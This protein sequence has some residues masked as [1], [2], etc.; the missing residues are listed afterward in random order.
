[1][2][3]RAQSSLGNPLQW[4][5]DGNSKLNAGD[6][7]AA[8]ELY[9]KGIES[10][11]EL[12][13]QLYSNRAQARAQLGKDSDAVA[14]CRVAISYNPQNAKPYWQAAVSSLRLN[15]CEDAVDFCE[16]A[17]VVLP[18]H[19]ELSQLLK[20]VQGVMTFSLLKRVQGVEGVLVLLAGF[21]DCSSLN[22]LWRTAHGIKEAFNAHVDIM[23]SAMPGLSRMYLIGGKDDEHTDG[24]GTSSVNIFQSASKTW[25]KGKRLPARLFHHAACTIGHS[26]FVSG[27]WDM[28]TTL[29]LVY[30]LDLLKRVRRWETI[31]KMP[32]KRAGH[33]A[34]SIDSTV[35]I[36]GGNDGRG[37]GSDSPSAVDALDVQTGA[38]SR[39]APMATPRMH[40]SSCSLDRFGYVIGGN[41][42][43]MTGSA[44]SSVER[45]DLRSNTWQDVASLVTPRCEAAACVVQGK[46][47]ICGG[48]TAQHGELLYS[49]ESYDPAVDVWIEIASMSRPR[50]G[51]AACACDG[52]VYVFG[53]DERYC[54]SSWFNSRYERSIESFDLASGKWHLE[55]GMKIG[56]GLM[57][58]V[59]PGSHLAPRV[60]HFKDVI[61]AS[62][63]LADLIF[64][65]HLKRKKEEDDE[66]AEEMRIKVVCESFIC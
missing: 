46:L 15:Q 2:S 38:W 27:G 23:Q 13:S 52:T 60:G 25:S 32:I 59:T 47:F 5:D 8:E 37:F 31:A 34:F 54:N 14:D 65:A 33:V 30:H 35:F 20:R 56:R 41:T 66:L 48:R 36:A 62:Q 7:L 16:S 64:Q 1:M 21:S 49:S 58:G 53:S 29:D 26:I 44:L 42:Y 19:R 63:E 24:P 22:S 61:T 3:D 51:M 28:G 39:R 17:L 40:M 6:A 4:K 9:T 55:Q 12:L 11:G 43:P 18:K 57:M 10:A 45:Y 50:A